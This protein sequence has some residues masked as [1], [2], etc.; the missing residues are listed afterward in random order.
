MSARE[1]PPALSESRQQTYG[2]FR[3]DCIPGQIPSTE[4][5]RLTHS[6]LKILSIEDHRCPSRSE[7]TARH[8]VQLH[9]MNQIPPTVD[10]IGG[11]HEGQVPIH[12]SYMCLNTDRRD[13]FLIAEQP[14]LD[15]LPRTLI[16]TIGNKWWPPVMR[17]GWA[18]VGAPRDKVLAYAKEHDLEQFDR[19]FPGFSELFTLEEAY[20][21]M[22]KEMGLRFYG[23]VFET[24]STVT[25]P[26][27]MIYILS[28]Y[29]NYYLHLG[30][31]FTDEVVE[32][33]KE[34]FGFEMDPKWY[35]DGADSI[36]PGDF[37]LS[38]H[39]NVLQRSRYRYPR[40]DDI[41]D[42][43]KYRPGGFHPVSV[44]DFFDGGRYKVLH[45]LGF[46][47]HLPSGLLEI[48]ARESVPRA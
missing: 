30:G 8:L 10:P 41:E 24:G 29:S 9:A 20:R 40:L 4:L 36:A 33:L 14:P 16:P 48:N 13:E 37:A 25:R 23:Y 45:K 3:G 7:I 39:G 35:L 6:L 12:L 47:A 1:A 19:S 42:L 34:R 32:K 27:E 15:S 43:E 21:H 44:G 5:L 2:L 18:I 11:P 31:Q 26:P 38:K 46:G 17:Y 28:L 22:A